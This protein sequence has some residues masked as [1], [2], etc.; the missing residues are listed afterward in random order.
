MKEEKKKKT[1]QKIFV[2]VTLLLSIG[3]LLYFLFTTGGG[4]LT[5]AHIAKTLR[6]AWLAA[7]VLA[8]VVCWVLEGWEVNLLC[9]HLKPDFRFSNSFT[10]TMVGYLYGALTPFSSGGHPM[11]IYTLSGMGMDAGMA[12][13]VVAVNTLSYQVV[14]VL[15]ALVMVVA[16]LHYFQTA[17]TNFSF[18][19]VIGLVTN[20]IF[21]ALVF[22]FLISEKTTDRILRCIIWG[23]HRMKLCR[24]PEER[25]ESIHSQLQVFHDASRLMGRS[26]RLYLAVSG[27]TAVQIALNSLIPY[28]IYLS[29]NLRGASVTDMI[30]AQIFVTM[31]SAFVPL[32]GSSGGAESGFYLF[33]GKY[34]GSAIFPAI[35]LWRIVTYY[36]NI[37]FGSV[38]AYF[39]SG[40]NKTGEN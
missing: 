2:A 40:M 30:A 9:R 38:F 6:G 25:Y 1:G 27:L 21:I 17:I 14:M 26:H 31:V 12:G 29:F 8:T 20:C 28:F 16:K 22:L 5:L 7:A 4:I 33:F 13:S 39:G 19:T 35:L 23:L 11:Q 24:H 37:L 32:P 15:S 18:L 10:V 36:I 34:F 3:V